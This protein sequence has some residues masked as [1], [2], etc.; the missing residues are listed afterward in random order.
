MRKARVLQSSRDGARSNL[1]T[2]HAVH[3]RSARNNALKRERFRVVTVVVVAAAAAACVC[4][5][6]ST[7]TGRRAL[8]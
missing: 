8:Q 7:W 2:V 5:C 1:V 3:G 4:L 6:R